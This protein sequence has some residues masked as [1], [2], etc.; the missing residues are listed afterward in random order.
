M[1]RPRAILSRIMASTSVCRHV[2]LRKNAMVSGGMLFR[3]GWH[4]PIQWPIPQR[5]YLV[6][7]TDRTRVEQQKG[8]V[9]CLVTMFLLAHID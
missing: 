8:A 3:L 9:A 4:V 7:S 2:M 1:V 5:I 6:G